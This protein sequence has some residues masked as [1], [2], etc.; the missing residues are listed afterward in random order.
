MNRRDTLLAFSAAA[1]PLVTGAVLRPAEAADARAL[2]DAAYRRQTLKIGSLAKLSSEIALAKATRP[3][4]KQFA[5]FEV[6]EQTAVAQVLTDKIDPPPPPL[7]A[8]ERRLLARLRGLSG[9]TF[10][11]V[12]VLAQTEGHQ[13]LRAIQREYLGSGRTRDLLH[14]ARLADT[15]IGEHLTH[16]R[17]LRALLGA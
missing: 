15:T 5:R 16:L 14:I 17:T 3:E 12:Y 9:I 4:V 7:T 10:D 6:A 13:R 1:A 2:S 8:E 11:R